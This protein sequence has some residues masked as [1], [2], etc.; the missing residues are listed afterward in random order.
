MTRTLRALLGVLTLSCL[1]VASGGQ[2]VPTEAQAPTWTS[3]RLSGGPAYE[4]AVT[5]VIKTAKPHNILTES[6]LAAG[7]EMQVQDRGSDWAAKSG[8]GPAIN[9]VAGPQGVAY[10]SSVA[11]LTYRTRDF[12][13]TWSRI[14]VRQGLPVRFVAVSPDYAFDKAAYALTTNDWHLYDTQYQN[15]AVAYSPLYNLDETTFVATSLGVYRW[16]RDV[17]TWT[18]MSKPGGNTPVFG[19]DGGPASSQGLILPAEYGDDPARRS[20][21]DLHTVF[22]YNAMGVYRS[23]DDGE[24]WTTLALPGGVEQVNDLAVSNGWPAD[25]VVAVA[26]EAPGVVGYV[27]QDNGATWR[28]VAG[29]DGLVGTSVAMAVD[30]APVPEPDKNWAGTVCLPT[31]FRNAPVV[32]H[33]A[34]VPPYMGSREMFLA[35]DGD[36]VYHSTDAGQTWT[37]SPASFR[38][39]Q[40]TS[41]EFLPGGDG[42]A[43]L[44]GSETAGLYRSSDTGES[45]SFVDS[46]LPRGSGSSIRVLRASPGFATDRT[47][48]LAASYGVWTSRDA[49]ASWSKTSGPEDPHTLAVSPDFTSD[50]TVLCDG[51]LSRDAGATWELIPGADQ[52]S[53]T[54]AA[55]SPTYARDGTLWWGTDQVTQDQKYGLRKWD[56]QAKQ[57]AP[58]TQPQV[59]RDMV[60]SL[61]AIQVDPAEPPRV[62]AGMSRSLEQSFDNGDTWQRAGPLLG[63]VNEVRAVAR[64]EPY[65]TG[66][67]LAANAEGASWSTSRGST[68]ERDPRSPRDARW[69]AVS[70]DGRT[71]LI[72]LPAT[73]GRYEL[74]SA[75]LARAVGATANGGW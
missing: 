5:P 74:P 60:T 38:N 11:G 36:G 69:A 29:R 51:Y 9:V 24:T 67:I 42:T 30:F 34:V 53:W 46:G 18:L 55:F 41:L 45:W 10:V 3:V 54:A 28:P 32:T 16:T 68:W 64:A 66:I 72:T 1:A 4:L 12:G 6:V 71:F 14:T 39:A 56:D 22:A 13:K 49:G 52:F 59:S 21:P 7:T 33:P 15:A 31:L 26:V 17:R 57:W 19:S 58:V 65:A 20:D 50:R 70:P 44:A 40:A 27:S 8:T 75:V 62:F 73:V 61:A 37:A 25:P 48:F 2:V 47:L 35:T 63:Q 23:D 43:V